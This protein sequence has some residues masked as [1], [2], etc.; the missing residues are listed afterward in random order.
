[1]PERGAGTVRAL[2]PPTG[3]SPEER[4]RFRRA[5]ARKI[6]EKRLTVPALLILESIQP[7]SFLSSQVLIFFSPLIETFFSRADW[8]TLLTEILEDRRELRRLIQDIEE[9]E[10]GRAHDPGADPPAST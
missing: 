9:M 6:V 1:M 3:L 5:L 8:Y 7:I 2:P 10:D 4:T